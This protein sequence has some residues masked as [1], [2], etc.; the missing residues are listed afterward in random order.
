MKV[1]VR[2]CGAEAAAEVHRLTQVAFANHASLDPP[3][4]AL[5]ESEEDVR[6]DL[7]RG[8]GAL[9]T[10]DGATVG[11]LRY[12]VRP[13]WLHARRVA[14]DP[15]FQNRGIGRALMRWAE[16]EARRRGLSEVRLG[17]RRQLPENQAFYERLG[18]EVLAAHSHPGH[19]EVTWYEMGR[20]L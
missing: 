8:G 12:E 17:V 14:V 15:A 11:A 18:Y 20:R 5:R 2:G 19:A 16:E 3:S 6:R 9:A 10:V 1:D 4:G 13:F 7:E